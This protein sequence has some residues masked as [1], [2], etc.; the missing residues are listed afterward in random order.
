MTRILIFSLAILLQ[1]LLHL[2]GT[3]VHAADVELE[4]NVGYVNYNMSG[5]FT[6]RAIG[7]NGKWPIPGVELALGDIL[8]IHVNNRLDEPTS[9]HSHGIFQKGTNYYDGAVMA[10]ECGIPPNGSFTYRIHMKQAGTFWIHS[11][12][13]SQTTDGLRTSLIVRDPNEF[14][15]YDGEIILPLEDWFREQAT[16]IIK[17]FNNPDPH[18]RYKPIV[19]YGIIGGECTNSKRLKMVPGKTY[20]IRLLNIGASFE[21]HFQI[22]HHDLRVIEVDGVAVKEKRTSV[23]VTAKN[24]TSNNY[25]FHA[26][27]YT[28]LF[29]MPRYNP[30]NFT[31]VLEY[32]PHA[33]ILREVNSQWTALSD[34]DLQPLDNEPLMEPSVSYTLDAYSGVFDDQ[35]FRHSFGNIT[36]VAPQVPSLLTALTTGSLATR[37]EI[38]GR[39]SNTYVLR[40]QDVVQVTVN[41]HDYYTHPFHLHGHVFQIVEIGSIRPRDRS[42]KMALQVP[43]K[44]DTV[45]LRGGQY[46]ILR[47]RANNPGVW[48]F[49]CH[50][51]FHIM[52]GLQMTFVSAPEQIQER[53]ARLPDMFRENCIAQGIETKGNAV[54]GEGL[55]LGSRE[56]RGPNPYS[57]K[58]ESYNPPSEWEML[59]YILQGDMDDGPVPVQTMYSK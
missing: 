13:K 50:I 59:S 3:A 38:Y 45:I 20:R 48:L 12:F 26:D 16:V 11:H 32:A 34:L 30:L 49:H 10:T 15:Q 41:N 28:D 1:G 18:I 52:L 21:Y 51:D 29:Q 22:D 56:D 24:S 35:T 36:Y 58:F 40:Y 17:Q 8:I 4:W 39:Q 53:L 44:R 46:A 23:L 47:F 57:D 42:S 5:V 19:P 31:G 25:L 2:S 55:E 33:N 27:M 7:V 37:S 14:Y 6:R 9:L 54:G 43:A